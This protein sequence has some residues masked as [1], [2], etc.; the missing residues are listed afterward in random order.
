[1]GMRVDRTALVEHVTGSQMLGAIDGERADQHEPPDSVSRGGGRQHACR[2]HPL[3]EERGHRAA[4]RRSGVHERVAAVEELAT[5][6]GA[7]QLPDNELQAAALL[8]RDSILEC[9]SS[10]GGSDRT[11]YLVTAREQL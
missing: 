8:R 6:P 7:I 1:M 11:A 4:E 10:A 9:C 2:H 3:R 5:E